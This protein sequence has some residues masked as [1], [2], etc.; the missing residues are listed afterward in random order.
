MI[1]RNHGKFT[2]GHILLPGRDKATGR[3]TR[4]TMV[5]PDI[6]LKIPEPI[7]TPEPTPTPATEPEKP[8]E[9]TT[10]INPKSTFLKKPNEWNSY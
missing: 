5:E 2:M 9:S 3:F 6:V 1:E 4:K 10:I 8:K 7:P